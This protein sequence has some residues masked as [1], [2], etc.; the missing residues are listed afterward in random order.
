MAH[1][2]GRRCRPTAPSRCWRPRAGRVIGSA[3][4][5]GST[6]DVALAGQDRDALAE[7]RGLGPSPFLNMLQP[8][9]A[10]AAAIST[11]TRKSSGFGHCRSYWA[12]LSAARAGVDAEACRRS[13]R[14]GRGSRPGTVLSLAMAANSRPASAFLPCLISAIAV[15][16]PALPNHGLPGLASGCS[17]AMTSSGLRLSNSSAVWRI[18][19]SVAIGLGKPLVAGDLAIFGDRQLGVVLLERERGAGEQR[20]G[21]DRLAAALRQSCRAAAAPLPILPL[22]MSV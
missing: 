5:A 18:S 14:R 6:C 7:H 12:G 16:S 15:I 10:S 2:L 13:G 19:A 11:A 3:A 17:R 22:P 8:L 9:A 20:R 1:R 4:V 21:A